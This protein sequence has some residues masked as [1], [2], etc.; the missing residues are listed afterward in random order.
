MYAYVFRDGNYVSMNFFL[1]Y[2]GSNSSIFTF[3]YS[4]VVFG[5]YSFDFYIN[6]PN[7]ADPQLL[8]NTTFEYIDPNPE[9]DP[10]TEFT[11]TVTKTESQIQVD[12]IAY[13]AF[14]SGNQPILCGNKPLASN[15]DFEGSKIAS[16]LPVT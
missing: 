2:H 7:L 5:N 8:C 9:P 6:D 10:V 4:P 12:I 14:V 11:Y 3:D 13:Y 1:T 15:R 16:S